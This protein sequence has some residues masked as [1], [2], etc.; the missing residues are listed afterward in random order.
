MVASICG[1]DMTKLNGKLGK[2][3]IIVKSEAGNE[4]KIVTLTKYL[5]TICWI[6]VNGPDT[7]GS[8]SWETDTALPAYDGSEDNTVED[9]QIRLLDDP[10]EDAQDET[11]SWLPVPNTKELET[12]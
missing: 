6:G 9:E 1:V 11:L 7:H 5:G 3:A 8:P 4:G 2:L 10:D 12:A